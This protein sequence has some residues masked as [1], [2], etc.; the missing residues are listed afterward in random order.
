MGQYLKLL[1][2]ASPAPGRF[3]KWVP[4]A[5]RINWKKN[6]IWKKKVQPKI[7]LSVPDYIND[8]TT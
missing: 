2:G 6:Y 1:K 5:A 7:Q 8:I 4:K 3:L